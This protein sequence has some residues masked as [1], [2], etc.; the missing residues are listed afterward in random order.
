[1]TI[2]AK[3]AGRCNKCFQPIAIGEKIEWT[4]G[5]KGAA[6]IACPAVPVAPVNLTPKPVVVAEQSAIVEFLQ[7]AIRSGLKAPKV[8][9]LAPKGGELRLSLAGNTSKYPGSI[10]VKVNG[11]WVGRINPDGTKS[12]YDLTEELLATINKIALN[13]AAA[14]KEYGALMGRCSFCNLQ[15][16]DAGSVE[17]GYGPICA[18]HY[19]LPHTAKGTP[20]VK[21][22]GEVIPEPEPVLL[23]EAPKGPR[24]K[25]VA[26]E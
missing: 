7:R 11:V 8:R 16:T 3:F 15:L 2:T 24:F 18:G 21:T 4:R 12:G 19:G 6:H 20:N 26:A 17:V 25:T 9:F 5:V 13:P 1:M 14:A 23:T 22:V 10:Q